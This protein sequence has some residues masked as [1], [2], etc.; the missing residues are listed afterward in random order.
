MPASGLEVL[1]FWTAVRNLDERAC[2][3]EVSM[4][5]KAYVY[6]NMIYYINYILYTIHIEAGILISYR[7]QVGAFAASI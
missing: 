3:K 5:M 7:K 2:H 4:Y 6:L 1:T